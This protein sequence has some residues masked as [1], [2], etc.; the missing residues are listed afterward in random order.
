MARGNPTGVWIEVRQPG[1]QRQLTGSAAR[2]PG[3]QHPG[4]A[5]WA[6]GVKSANAFVRIK[7]GCSGRWRSASGRRASGGSIQSSGASEQRHQS[8]AHQNSAIQSG[9]IQSSAIGSAIQTAPSSGIEE[10]AASRRV[11]P[12]GIPVVP[13]GIRCLDRSTASGRCSWAAG[14]QRRASG[15]LRPSARRVIKTAA[16]GDSMTL[17]IAVVWWC[18]SMVVGG[19]GPAGDA[20]GCT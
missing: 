13:L 12:V 2:R 3:L 10:S 4:G 15:A 16:L 9:S 11:R 19:D 7:A 8:G 18:H 14:R 17:L 6:A 5:R 20:Y 1:R